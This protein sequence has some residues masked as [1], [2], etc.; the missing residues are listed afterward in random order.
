MNDDT[1]V[2]ITSI[3]E[4]MEMS[5]AGGGSVHGHTGVKKVKNEEETLIREHIRKKIKKV[6]SSILNEQ[7]K[8]WIK[9]LNKSYK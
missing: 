6:R 7:Y 3:K 5:S 2:E 8:N 9:E 4:L 1:I